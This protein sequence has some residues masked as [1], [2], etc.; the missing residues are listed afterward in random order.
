MTTAVDQAIAALEPFAK[1]AASLPSHD[2]HVTVFG[3]ALSD[4]RAAVRA[5][6]VLLSLP[7]PAEIEEMAKRLDEQA[8]AQHSY[9]SGTTPIEDYLGSQAAAL[10]RRF[11]PK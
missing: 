7:S 1:Q 2:D 9:S 8:A 4:C 10:L 3:V 5:I 6:A 11:L